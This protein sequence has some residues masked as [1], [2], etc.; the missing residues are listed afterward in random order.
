MPLP[1]EYGPVTDDEIVYRRVPVSQGWVTERGVSMNAFKAR[2]DDDTGISVYRA[3]FLSVE[4]AAR[5]LSKQGYYVRSG[6]AARVDRAQERRVPGTRRRRA[7]GR[8]HRR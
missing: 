3:R 2:P 4:D 7:V 1:G 5:G 6:R 8:V